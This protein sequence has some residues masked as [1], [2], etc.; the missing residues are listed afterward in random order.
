M[1]ALLERLTH[2][3]GAERALWTWTGSHFTASRWSDL[4][5]DA[6]GM[7]A[8]LRQRGVEPGTPV[9]CVLTNSADAASAVLAVWLAGGVVA[10]LPIPA[11]SM[12]GPEYVRQLDALCHRLGARVLLLEDALRPLLD[13]LGGISTPVASYRSLHSSRRWDPEPPSAD[14]TA[15]IQYS[16]G[17]T[18]HPRGCA[19][20]LRAI[21]AHMHML[22]GA[23]E[24][25]ADS[26]RG[27]S[28]LPLSHDM[29]LFGGLML[30]WV[31][32]APFALGTPQRF[33]ERPGSWL[34]D[35]ASFGATVTIG[36]NFGLELAV[37]A[38]HAEMPRE[39]APLKACVLG[40]ERIEWHTLM[41]ASDLLG[42]FGMTRGSLK[43]AYGLAEATLA[44]SIPRLEDDVR[45]LAVDPG[46]LLAGRVV[47]AED[48][49]SAARLVSVGRPLEGVSVRIDE[50]GGPGTTPLGE[51]VGEIVI[52]SPSLTSG[53]VDDPQ[54]S[55]ERLVDGELRSGDLGFF[56]EG[57]LHVVG[58]IDDM[59]S[60]RGRNVFTAEVEERLDEVAGVRPGCVVLV[61]VV[62]A[63][64][65][66]LVVVAEPARGAGELSQVASA[67]ARRASSAAELEI[68]ECVFL[69]RGALPKTPS[70][71]VQRFR[72]RATALDGG[73][74][75]LARVS[76]SRAKRTR[77]VAAAPPAA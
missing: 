7:A 4:V 56:R 69:Q 75:V 67:L 38:A 13:A 14:A 6:H 2:P 17:S 57:E 73:E 35:C 39:A 12:G 28:W 16:S 9:G 47:D 5:L 53:Y 8:S 41:A 72:C 21:D 65:S 29:G 46:A 44:V 34:E 32:R 51:G 22:A 68:D 58:R 33:L 59:I 71:K 24:L 76:T 66:R 52:S 61:D 60:V 43:P 19:L 42:P 31:M 77:R 55:S 3:D 18:S 25:D 1:T 10:S 23:L 37:R 48:P 36:P 54:R 70:G 30:P 62:D 26:D 74:R 11:R 64:G 50:S 40:G 63:E 45:A 20:S 49:A 27:M 15:F